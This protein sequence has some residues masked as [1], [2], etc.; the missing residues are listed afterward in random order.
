MV[1]VHWS[2]TRCGR[3][4]YDETISRGPVSRQLVSWYFGGN[5]PPPGSFRKTTGRTI[6][7]ETSDSTPSSR[8]HDQGNGGHINA[9]EGEHH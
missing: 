7:A 8:G 6:R 3:P 2:D 5:A 1:E 9:T 4:R